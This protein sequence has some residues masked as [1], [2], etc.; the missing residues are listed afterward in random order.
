MKVRRPTL[1]LSFLKEVSEVDIDF[2]AD[3]MDR[4]L[5][6]LNQQFR[7][8]IESR[9][10]YEA[11][12]NSYKQEFAKLMSSVPPT[13]VVIDYLM[14]DGEVATRV[15]DVIHHHEELAHIAFGLRDLP[16]LKN[17]VRLC[18]L[19][20]SLIDA[21]DLESVPVKTVVKDISKEKLNSTNLANAYIIYKEIELRLKKFYKINLAIV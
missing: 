17:L 20:Y 6:E 11:H 5:S 8:F 15:L 19:K 4:F 14:K 10:Y 12:E 9:L 21:E 18:A 2:L 3:S 1:D 16:R 13:D 7:M